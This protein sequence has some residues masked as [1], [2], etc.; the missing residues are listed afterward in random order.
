MTLL[1]CQWPKSTVE[2]FETQYTVTKEIGKLKSK[3]HYQYLQNQKRMLMF[4]MSHLLSASLIIFT[5]DKYKY[6]L[7]V[8]A[9]RNIVFCSFFDMKK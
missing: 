3:R 8:I 6:A 5:I 9:F 2:G 7:I 4:R 1:F